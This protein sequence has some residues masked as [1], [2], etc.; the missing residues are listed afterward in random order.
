MGIIGLL[1]GAAFIIAAASGAFDDGETAVFDVEPGECA[2]FDFDPNAD[3]IEVTTV[4]V[5]N[6]DEP[7]EAEVI[8]VDELNPGGGLPYPSTEQFNET[9]DQCTNRI[10][11][12]VAPDVDLT[13]YASFTVIPNEDSWD[14]ED[15]PSVCF[16]VSG[17]RG[18]TT[19]SLMTGD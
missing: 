3:D 10:P 18:T 5:V 8:F 15:G 14:D 2:N 12:E 17:D 4:E 9:V 13:D 16:A 11:G 1:A 6:C 19:G 7:H